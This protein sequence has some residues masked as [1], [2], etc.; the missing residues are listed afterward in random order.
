MALLKKW[1]DDKAELKFLVLEML[2]VY[3]C[4]IESIEFGTEDLTKDM[5]ISISLI[6]ARSQS[7]V[8][9]NLTGLF[10]R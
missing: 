1:K 9:D 7:K 2:I 4:K 6:E 3:T 5:G 10:M 8:T